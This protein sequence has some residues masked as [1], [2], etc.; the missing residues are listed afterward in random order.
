MGRV[1][2]RRGRGRDE[3]KSNGWRFTPIPQKRLHHV[4]LSEWMLLPKV[5]EGHMFGE[6]VVNE[7]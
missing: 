7:R 2:S 3:W 6:A 4:S 1:C 5:E